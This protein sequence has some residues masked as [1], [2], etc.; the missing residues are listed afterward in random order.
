M[1]ELPTELPTEMSV[2]EALV[3]GT[4]L[5]RLGQLDQAEE[6]YGAVLAI[7]PEH[8]DA[9]QFMG[10]LRYARG[11]R[12][13]GIALMQQSIALVP[14]APGLHVNLGNMLL[15]SARADEATEAYERAAALGAPSAVLMNNLGVLRRHQQRLPE[16]EAAYRQA[17]QIDPEF[18][19]AYNNLG[20]LLA[21]QGQHEAALDQYC[22]ALE[23]HPNSPATRRLAALALCVLGRAEAAARIY[24]EWLAEEPDNP[25]PQHYLAA[26]TGEGVPQRASDAYVEATF[27]A[28]ADSFDAKLEQLTYRAPG[29]VARAVADIA[30]AA[31]GDG[32]PVKFDM[33]DAGCGTGLCGPLLAPHAKRLVGVDLSAGMLAKA[34][35]RGGYDELV[36]AELVD[37][38]RARPAAFD[39]IVSADTLCYFGPLEEAAEAAFGALRDDGHLVFT[40]EALRLAEPSAADTANPPASPPAGFRLNHHGRYSHSR[41][42][43]ER[44]LLAAGF[45]AATFASAILR[46]EAGRSVEGFVVTARRPGAAHLP[47]I[48]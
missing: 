2:E 16:A 14:N 29:L 13:E 22:K 37:D 7:A 9:L 40:V 5:H 46:R 24:R 43:I 25:L 10:I 15:D 48:G 21:S 1:T 11:K 4:R 36:K 17:A 32:P 42:Y 19:D 6:V 38:L 23:M 8:P 30:A 35:Q 39:V 45:E 27:D 47:A 34:R 12:P 31:S 28:F 44:T 33:L 41:P 3:F 20:N 18:I 26:C